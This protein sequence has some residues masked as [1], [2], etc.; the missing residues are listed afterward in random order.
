ML[1]QLLYQLCLIRL[2]IAT[3]TNLTGPQGKTSAFLL[4]PS[5]RPFHQKKIS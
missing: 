1:L 4:K 2:C 5:G 3:Q